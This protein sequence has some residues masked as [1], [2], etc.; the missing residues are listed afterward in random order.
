MKLTELI[1]TLRNNRNSLTT[2]IDTLFFLS[3]KHQT[4]N[5]LHFAHDTVSATTL[6]LHSGRGQ[7]PRAIYKEMGVTNLASISHPTRS[8]TSLKER[9]NSKQNRP[10]E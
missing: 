7:N 3:V 2:G 10:K 5:I 4:V 1:L 6:Q 9:E 8:N